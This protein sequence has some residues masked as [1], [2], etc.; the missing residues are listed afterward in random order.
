[1]AGLT[2]TDAAFSVRVPFQNLVTGAWIRHW[3]KS[4]CDKIWPSQMPHP[5]LCSCCTWRKQ[6]RLLPIDL[7]PRDNGPKFSHPHLSLH[8][9]MKIKN[10]IMLLA[11]SIIK[12][13]FFLSIFCL[14]A[15]LYVYISHV[16]C[17]VTTNLIR[18]MRL[19]YLPGNKGKTDLCSY[20]HIYMYKIVRMN[21]MNLRSLSLSLSLSL[22]F[23]SCAPNFGETML[24][25]Y[26]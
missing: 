16:A 14:Q 9:Q 8:L 7:L 18:K 23:A 10:P 25:I 4:H 22:S 21:S 12:R 5:T 3:A 26:L 15:R 1:M 6:C 20:Q 11:I 19:Y 13:F 17:S 24:F 2:A